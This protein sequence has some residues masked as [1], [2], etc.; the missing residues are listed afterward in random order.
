MSRMEFRVYHPEYAS[1]CEIHGGLVTG[2][3][4][5]PAEVCYAEDVRQLT[6]ANSAHTRTRARLLIRALRLRAWGHELE[7][8][9]WSEGDSRCE[10][11]RT[12]YG[13]HRDLR[14]QSLATADRIQAKYLGG[15]CE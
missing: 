7:C 8:I 11:S 2:Y 15:E 10:T 9:L 3:E 13:R 1:G 14:E 6:I 5:T 12:E 4:K